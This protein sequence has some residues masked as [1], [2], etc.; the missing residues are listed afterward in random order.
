MPDMEGDGGDAAATAV[1]SPPTA[2]APTADAADRSPAVSG[3]GSTAAWAT[4]SIL[5]DG[6]V[7]RTEEEE[8]LPDDEVVRRALSSYE[9]ME[10]SVY[11]D[12]AL[13]RVKRGHV[14][15]CSCEYK[16]GT[17]PPPYARINQCPAP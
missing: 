5:L 16:P 14:M 8:A 3:T 7:I 2:A 9:P 6:E 11:L 15:A 12:E 13:R 1:A 10:R 17:L 4:S